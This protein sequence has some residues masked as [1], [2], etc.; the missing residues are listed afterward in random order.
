MNAGFV[1]VTRY[2]ARCPWRVLPRVYPSI[3]GDIGAEAAVRRMQKYDTLPVDYFVA[4]LGPDWKE[5]I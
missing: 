5:F 3:G 2:N 1:I 4:P